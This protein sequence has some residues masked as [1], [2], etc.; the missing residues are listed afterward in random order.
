MVK[1][2]FGWNNSFLETKPPAQ[3]S[4]QPVHPKLGRWVSS[5]SSSFRETEVRRTHKLSKQQ[6]SNPFCASSGGREFGNCVCVGSSLIRINISWKICNSQSARDWRKLNRVWVAKL[7]LT[8]AWVK[9]SG[10]SG[11]FFCNKYSLNNL[12]LMEKG[13]SFLRRRFGAEKESRD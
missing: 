8:E 9:V 5:N 2:P 10:R 3:T 6:E 13:F 11:C 12:S 7:A 4:S 1:K